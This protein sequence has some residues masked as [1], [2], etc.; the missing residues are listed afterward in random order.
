MGIAKRLTGPFRS[1]FNG[2]FEMVK[3]EVRAHGTGAPEAGDGAAWER[4][5]ELEHHLAEQAVHQARSLTRLTEEVAALAE[6]L[7]EL[8]RTVDRLVAALDAHDR[9]G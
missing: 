3:E 2:H 5:G 4:V 8:E 1:Y 6:R 7:A 9:R